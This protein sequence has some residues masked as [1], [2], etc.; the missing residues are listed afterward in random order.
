[1]IERVRLKKQFSASPIFWAVFVAAL[2]YFVDAYDIVL[3]SVIRVK[4]LQGIG[5]PEADIFNVGVNLL[6]W[7]LVGLLVGGVFWGVLGDKKGRLSVLFGSI[8]IYS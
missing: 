3:F 6:N 7:Q 5:V 1:M 4:S 2:G 8:F